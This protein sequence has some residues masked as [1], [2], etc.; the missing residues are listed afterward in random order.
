[1]KISSRRL[2]VSRLSQASP[3]CLSFC[4]QLMGMNNMHK[5]ALLLSALL[6]V[7]NLAVA[8]PEDDIPTLFN[9]FVAAQNAHEPIT[10]PLNTATPNASFK[11][12]C[13]RHAA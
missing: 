5:S 13:I 12:T 8:G 1:V 3:Q 9:A 10:S 2:T 6:T 7:P 4:R 11:R